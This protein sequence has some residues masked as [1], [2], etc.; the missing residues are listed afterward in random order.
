[1]NDEFRARL[2]EATKMLADAKSL[3]A[4]GKH[5][6]AM[7]LAYEV[8]EYAAAAYL[9]GVTGQNLWPNDATYD[10][11]AKTIQEPNRHPSLLPEDISTISAICVLREAYEPALLDETTPQDAQQMIDHVAALAELVAKIAKN[12]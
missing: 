9:S 5:G 10:L 7:K 11:F 3:N 6:A 8:S 12:L 1:M 2:A 4:I